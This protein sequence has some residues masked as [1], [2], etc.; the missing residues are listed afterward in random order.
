LL[1][2]HSIALPSGSFALETAGQP[3]QAVPFYSVL[4][5]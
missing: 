5:V 2:L 3:Y 1:L 4:T